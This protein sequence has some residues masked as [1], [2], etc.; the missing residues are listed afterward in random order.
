M[1]FIGSFYGWSDAG[2]VSSETALHLLRS[3]EFQLVSE[4]KGYYIMTVARPYF[5]IE[6][7][8][9]KQVNEPSTQFFLCE[10]ESL[11]LSTGFEPDLRWDRYAEEVFEILKKYNVNRIF[12]IG[13]LYDRVSHRMNQR[14][15][16]VTSKDSLRD[17]S[18]CRVINYYGPGSIHSFLVSESARRNVD[19]TTFWFSVPIYV[20]NIYYPGI[21]NALKFISE[22]IRISIPLHEVE[23]LSQGQIEEIERTVKVDPKLRSLLEEIEKEDVIIQ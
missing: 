21:L 13:S 6:G 9:V 14:I 23:K 7:G 4:L 15:S 1:V 20:P 5:L 17:E 2:R 10:K 19:A 18:S 12:T 11:L 3:L 8:L 22:K 16:I